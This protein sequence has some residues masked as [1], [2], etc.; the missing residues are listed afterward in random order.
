MKEVGIQNLGL[1]TAIYGA[2]KFS[3]STGDSRL[4]LPHQE[5]E[6]QVNQ[7]L[8]APVFCKAFLFVRMES[9]HNKF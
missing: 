2:F 9:Q 7:T 8:R 6:E 4:G 1:S 3:F 5:H